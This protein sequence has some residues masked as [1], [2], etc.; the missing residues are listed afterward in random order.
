MI[1]Q[2]RSWS[3]LWFKRTRSDCTK[4][5]SSNR[6]KKRP[7]CLLLNIPHLRSIRQF[8]KACFISI[9]IL[10]ISPQMVR[11]PLVNQTWQQK[12][13]RIHIH[14]QASFSSTGI[15]QAQVLKCVLFGGRFPTYK[16]SSKVILVGKSSASGPCS[17]AKAY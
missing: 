2:S 11:N 9:N 15:L 16:P 12:F 8:L 4:I 6:I 10:I 7:Q 14:S 3:N 17:V 1:I 5:D 13:H